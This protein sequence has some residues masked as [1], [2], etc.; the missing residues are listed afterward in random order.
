MVSMYRI[1]VLNL[2]VGQKGEG[3]RKGES[4]SKEERKKKGKLERNEKERKKHTKEDIVE[5]V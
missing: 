5:G 4:E 3:Y 1:R 2:L